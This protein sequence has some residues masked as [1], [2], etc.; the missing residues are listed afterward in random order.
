MT[1]QRNS[2]KRRSPTKIEGQTSC[3]PYLYNIL[4]FS[5]CT[6]SF[7]VGSQPLCYLINI[8]NLKPP[9]IFTQTQAVPVQVNRV[10][11]FGSGPK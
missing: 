4:L 11:N 8:D 5:I 10:S 1:Y 7:T 6:F 3:K 2:N 9:Q